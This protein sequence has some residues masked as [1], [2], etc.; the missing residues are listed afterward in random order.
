M[1][2]RLLS[3]GWMAIGAFAF[4]LGHRPP[5]QSAGAHNLSQGGSRPGGGS[6]S[7]EPRADPRF[8]AG[9]SN[10]GRPDRAP[11]KCRATHVVA[12]QRILAPQRFSFR[13][14]PRL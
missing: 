2:P 14:S 5:A 9:A 11:T 3:N 4:S 13:L 12:D 1:L 10:G 8:L 7:G 6:G